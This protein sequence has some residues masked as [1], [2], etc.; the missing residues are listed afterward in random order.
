MKI[1]FID[2]TCVMCDGLT[3]WLVGRLKPSSGLKISTLSSPIVEE[4]GFQYE[5]LQ[6]DAIM[7]FADGER[8][9]G[10]EAV[11]HV[12]SEMIQPWRFLLA[13]VNVA[14]SRLRESMYDWVAKNRKR[15]FGT[16]EACSLELRDS[17]RFIH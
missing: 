12:S 5:I 7:L 6:R 8:F 1:L 2:S 4:Y 11:K 3:R 17:Y 16:Q 15:V 14:P 10:A 13:I 9:F